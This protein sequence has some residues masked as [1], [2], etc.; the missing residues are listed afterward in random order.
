MSLPIGTVRSRVHRLRDKL[1][2]LLSEAAKGV[3]V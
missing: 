1:R 2:G 3:Q